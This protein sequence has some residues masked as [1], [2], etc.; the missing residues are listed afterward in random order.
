MALIGKVVLVVSTRAR[1]SGT[2]LVIVTL[3]SLLLSLAIGELTMEGL[4]P[5]EKPL[6]AA[7]LA[8]ALVA[9]VLEPVEP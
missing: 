2:D 5:L 9:S 7:T 3:T 6:R 1:R 8:A 4:T